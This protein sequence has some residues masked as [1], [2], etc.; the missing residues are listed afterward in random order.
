MNPWLIPVAA[1]EIRLQ[2]PPLP[3]WFA[4]IFYRL[5]HFNEFY[6]RLPSR[7]DGICRDVFHDRSCE[8]AALKQTALW[9]GLIWISTLFVIDS[10]R[11]TMADPGLAFF[12]LLCFWSWVRFSRGES[13]CLL[14]LFYISLAM[15]TFAKGPV[16][17][18]HLFAAIVTFSIC[19]RQWP[20]GKRQWIWHAMGILLV[21]GIFLPW[22]LHVMHR[23][24][25]AL[26]LWRYESVG[27]FLDN[28][29]DA[30]LV[31]LSAECFSDS[32]CRG[33]S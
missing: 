2:K 9:A 22:P 32:G 8:T 1:G 13:V 26:D 19:Y 23:V 27:E 29:E 15:G 33:H 12:T 20:R 10:Y 25:H 16:I 4:A 14:I 24:P 6:S 5:F 3:Y 21:L 18:L 7:F 11:K 31:V 30:A 28:I 17:Y